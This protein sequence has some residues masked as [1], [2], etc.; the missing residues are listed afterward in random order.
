MPSDSSAQLIKFSRR[1]LREEAALIEPTG[2]DAVAFVAYE[3]LRQPLHRIFGAGGCLSLISRTLAMAVVKTP[4]LGELRARSDGRL[5]GW[6]EMKDKP[7]KRAM[8]EG[9]VVLLAELFELLL[10]FLGPGITLSLVRE[11]WPSLKD[12]NFENVTT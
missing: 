7:D 12:V 3:R 4:W 11:A 2:A 5:E 8:V 6:A 9:E 1:V 10:T